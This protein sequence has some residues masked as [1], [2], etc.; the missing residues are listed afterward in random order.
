MIPRI[1]HQI[2]VGNISPTE[3]QAEQISE[4]K[5]KLEAEGIVHCFWTND[6]Y[7]CNVPDNIKS[8]AAACRSHTTHEINYGAFEADALR[9]FIMLQHGGVYLDCDYDLVRSFGDLM[10]GFDSRP[11]FA[12]RWP[13]RTAWPCNAFLA[14][15]PNHSFY[16]SVVES[17]QSPQKNGKPHYIGPAWLGARLSEYHKEPISNH[18]NHTLTAKG[19]VN[20]LDEGNFLLRHRNNPGGF[21]EHRGWYTWRKRPMEKGQTPP[22]LALN[23]QHRAAESVYKRNKLLKENGGLESVSGC[24]SSM[25]SA[26][27][28]IKLISTIIADFKVRSI[29][30]C[31]C[32][33]HFWMQHVDLLGAAYHGYDILEELVGENRRKHPEKRFSKFDAVAQILPKSDL[34]ICRDFLFHLHFADGVRVLNNFR[35]SGSSLLLTTSFNQL[36]KNEDLSPSRIYGFRKINVMLEPYCLGEPVL[37]ALEF[38]DRSLNLYRLK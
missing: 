38:G 13:H 11:V 8:Y 21:L 19:L 31:P 29:S 35:E 5:R 26:A 16:R 10:A 28:A 6:N 25:R 17:L 9:Y 33:D 23:P 2:W 22:P 20:M 34:I 24:G 30:D 7:P 27:V 4:T 14:A 12:R 18:D 32:G 1:V 36:P 15:P 3:K 37:S